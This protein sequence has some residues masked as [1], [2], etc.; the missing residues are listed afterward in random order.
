MLKKESISNNVKTLVRSLPLV[1]I[2]GASLL[3]LPNLARQF[4]ILIVLLWVQVF[5]V[6]ECF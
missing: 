2:V 4:L 3:P 5:F 6:F 1:A